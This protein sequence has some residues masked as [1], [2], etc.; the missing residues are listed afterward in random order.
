M[1]LKEKKRKE[2]R[3]KVNRMLTVVYNSDDADKMY[4]AIGLAQLSLPAVLTRS[5]GKHIS[6]HIATNFRRHGV[7]HR[8]DI[9]GLD[10][11]PVISTQLNRSVGWVKITSL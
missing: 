4:I 9:L 11:G 8:N 1:E 6:T 5:R 2:K 3:T 7:A 10:D